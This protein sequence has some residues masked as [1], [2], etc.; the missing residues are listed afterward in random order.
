[1]EVIVQYLLDMCV[2]FSIIY[3]F[4]FSLKRIQYQLT[5]SDLVTIH[6]TQSMQNFQ[7]INSLAW[8]PK[9]FF[10]VYTIY[11][12]DTWHKTWKTKIYLWHRQLHVPHEGHL[13]INSNFMAV[14]KFKTLENIC[15]PLRQQNVALISLSVCLTSLQRPSQYANPK[16]QITSWVQALGTILSL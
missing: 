10:E 2:T 5:L 8:K 1:M 11:Y 4:S 13:L 3:L 6:I 7:P 15:I 16:S 12:A 14:D 9:I